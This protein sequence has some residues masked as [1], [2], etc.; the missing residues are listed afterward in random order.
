MSYA[1]GVDVGG[2]SVKI[3]LVDTQG[4]IVAQHR[5]LTPLDQPPADV[6]DLYA[7]A[8]ETFVEQQPCSQ[9]NVVGMGIGMPGQIDPTRQTSIHSNVPTLDGFPL[10]DFFSKR[11]QWPVA[12]DNDA[13]VAALAEYTFGAGQAINRLL[14]M[15]V[16]TGIG[17]GLVIDGMPYRSTRGCAGDPGHIIVDPTSQWRCRLG[18]RGCL[19]TVATS[20]ALEREATTLAQWLPDSALGKILKTQQRI[21]T[22]DVIDLAK[23][24]D[25]HAV[26]LIKKIGDWLGIGLVSWSYV[27][28][29]EVILIGGGLSVVEDLLIPQIRQTMLTIGMSAYVEETQLK[30]AMFGNDAGIIGAAALIMEEINP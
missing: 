16:G 7:R 19:E 17:A 1:L 6:V 27:F 23:D 11:F 3:G 9:T 25:A 2:G 4:Q 8:I 10:V 29:P 20:L 5:F 28:D 15:T 21:I 24:G 13:T 26:Q 22:S 18:C 30:P 12:L 14:V